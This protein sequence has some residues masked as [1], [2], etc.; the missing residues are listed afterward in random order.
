MLG[1]RWLA[2]RGP[3][4][5]DRLAL[6]AAPPTGSRSAARAAMSRTASPIASSCTPCGATPGSCWPRPSPVPSGSPGGPVCNS[7]TPKCSPCGLPRARARPAPPPR[8]ALPPA[9]AADDRARR[10][11]GGLDDPHRDLPEI[12]DFGR[13]LAQAVLEGRGIPC[14]K[15]TGRFHA[16]CISTF[17]YA[18]KD[19]AVET[20]E[21][22]FAEWTRTQVPDDKP[23]ALD[24]KVLRGSY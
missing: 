24:G 21:D 20:L 17:H 3:R 8:Q 19:V 10:P 22:P 9:R 5:L 6:L 11:R 15:K 1:D 16:P 12:S 14:R 13:A 4:T 18:L 23:L 2:L 7:P